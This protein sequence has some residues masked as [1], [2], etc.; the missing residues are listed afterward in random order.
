MTREN[1]ASG[2]NEAHKKGWQIVLP[3][4]NEKSFCKR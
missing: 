4:L 2:K 1:L 3:A